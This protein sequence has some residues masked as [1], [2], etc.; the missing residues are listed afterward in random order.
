[1]IVKI[2]EPELIKAIA[3]EMCFHYLRGKLPDDIEEIRRK[4]AEKPDRYEL[5]IPEAEIFV[6]KLKSRKIITKIKE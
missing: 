2:N 1:M 5:Y 3:I 4:V 6:E